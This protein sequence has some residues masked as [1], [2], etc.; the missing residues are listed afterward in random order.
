[1]KNIIELERKTA[2]LT[3]DIED[4]LHVAHLNLQALIAETRPLHSSLP[5]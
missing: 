3:E 2:E 5:S 1:M 4:I